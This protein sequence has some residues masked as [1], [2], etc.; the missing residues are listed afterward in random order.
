MRT[1]ANEWNQTKLQQDKKNPAV[2]TASSTWKA[3]LD[4]DTGRIPQGNRRKDAHQIEAITSALAGS[5][6]K[7]DSSIVV[8]TVDNYNCL[9]NVITTSE[10]IHAH[11]LSCSC[12]AEATSAL[13][14][15]GVEVARENFSSVQRILLLDYKVLIIRGLIDNNPWVSLAC[16]INTIMTVVVSPSLASHDGSGS[17]D[18]RCKRDP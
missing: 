14:K 16:D 12:V 9:R 2:K 10:D 1:T 8:M 13:M 6:M 5:Q 7:I 15:C 17:V 18:V 3:V 11:L 4:V